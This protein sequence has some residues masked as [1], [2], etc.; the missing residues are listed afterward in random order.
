MD[1]QDLDQLP[2]HGLAIDHGSQPVVHPPPFSARLDE[3]GGSEL[4]QMPGHGVLG[5]L[6]GMHQLAYTGLSA[7]QET[8]Q[9]QPHGIGERSEYHRHLLQHN[10]ILLICCITHILA[11][12][13]A[14]VKPLSSRGLVCRQKSPISCSA[15]LL[16]DRRANEGLS[17]DPPACRRTG[18]ELTP[19]SPFDTLPNKVSRFRNCRGARSTIFLAP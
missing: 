10:L 13:P 1:V 11:A 5:Q 4:S 19:T 15:R 3:P 18:I 17:C 16:L 7:Q 12:L 14:A 6:H 2:V 9:A 8:Q